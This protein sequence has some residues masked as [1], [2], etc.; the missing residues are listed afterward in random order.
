MTF[1]DLQ[2]GPGGVLEMVSSNLLAVT[3]GEADERRGVYTRFDDVRISGWGVFLKASGGPFGEPA[4]VVDRYTGN[5]RSHIGT[6]DAVLRDARLLS[7]YH[8]TAITG[9]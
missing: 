9:C 5:A 8:R 2:L 3:Q 7:C 6:D 1:D 4:E